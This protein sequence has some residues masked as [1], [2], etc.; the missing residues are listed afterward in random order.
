MAPTFPRRVELLPQPS[1]SQTKTLLALDTEESSESSRH[2]YT[3]QF[4]LFSVHIP[5]PQVLD[6]LPAVHHTDIIAVHGS[7]GDAYRTWQHENGYNWLYHIHEQFPGVR[8]Y[9]YGYDA[10]MAFSFGTAGLTNYARHLLSLIKLA[11][12][13]SEVGHASDC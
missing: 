13:D 12:A 4:G 7:G 9:S 1:D 3:E 6:S 2:N 10:G 8:V 11:R 5:T